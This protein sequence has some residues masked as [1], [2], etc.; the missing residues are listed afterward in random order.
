MSTPSSTPAA[1]P[2][3]RYPLRS[4]SRSGKKKQPSGELAES[5]MKA[6]ESQPLVQITPSSSGSRKSESV[7]HVTLPAERSKSP[8]R[9]AASSPES[10]KSKSP[11]VAR[12]LSA[13]STSLKGPTKQLALFALWLQRVWLAYLGY[14]ESHP[15]LTKS[16][17]A[18]VVS[19]VSDLLAQWLSGA[20]SST[21]E[22]K[23][24]LQAIDWISV[25]NQFIIGL[26]MRGMPLHYWYLFLTW[27]FRKWDGSR[28][29]EGQG[30]H[31]HLHS[32][33]ELLPLPVD[34]TGVT[35]TAQCPEW[36]VVVSG[37]QGSRARMRA[38]T[39]AVMRTQRRD[40][41][42]QFGSFWLTIVCLAASIVLSCSRWSG[43]G[44]RGPTHVR[45][46]HKLALFLGDWLV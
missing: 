44:A 13:A 15:V 3:A 37:E 11:M 34:S 5:E 26:V 22:G 2:N 6:A 7:L 17:T 29:V 45:P 38:R 21:G 9:T 36:V 39:S 16:L 10:L 24:L 12:R 1:A 30:R 27:L 31:K 32:D 25:R 4:R 33:Q 8:T 14:L 42:N 35:Q 20:L 23:S 18:A 41:R 40:S 28:A 46:V 19:V 43:Q